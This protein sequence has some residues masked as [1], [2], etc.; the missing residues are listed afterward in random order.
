MD[1]KQDLKFT[2]TDIP[3]VLLIEP[4]VF[5]D[6][7]GFFLESY[8]KDEFAKNGI[9]AEFVQDNHSLSKRGALR[10][11]HFQTAPKEQ[12]KLVRV[13]RGEV[14]DVAVDIRPGSKTFGKHVALLLSAAN[15]K[16]L[17]VPA[18]FAHG[19]L[20]LSAEAEFQYKVTELYSPAHER[21]LRWDD[22]ALGIA[23]PDAGAPVF[24]S[25]KDKKFPGL[26]ELK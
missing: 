19:Y 3:G 15:R 23:W 21:G 25:E 2:Q 8:R 14:F 22:P 13:V 24:L 6:A 11:L 16:M 18:G 20:T 26:K 9:T 5:E 12:A 17:F 10:G 7:R 4:Q 1:R